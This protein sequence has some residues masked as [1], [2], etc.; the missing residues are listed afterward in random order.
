MEIYIVRNVYNEREVKW[1]KKNA[2][3]EKR[4]KDKDRMKR[5]YLYILVGIT[6]DSNTFIIRF[7]RYIIQ[8]EFR[9]ILTTFTMQFY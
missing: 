5:T 2:R 4:K 1:N 3:N 6:V 7:T 8:E 9:T